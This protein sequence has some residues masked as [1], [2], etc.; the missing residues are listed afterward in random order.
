MRTFDKNEWSKNLY[1]ERIRKGLCPKCP[2]NKINK[3]T[4]WKLC[5]DCRRRKNENQRNSRIR[6]ASGRYEEN[7]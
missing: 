1:K 4:H 5:T 3:L 7:A 6:G 2:K